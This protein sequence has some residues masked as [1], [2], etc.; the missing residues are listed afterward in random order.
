MNSTSFHSNPVGTHVPD[1]LMTV[2]DVC[3]AVRLARSTIHSKVK[4][5]S[6]PSPIKLS[7]RCVRWRQKAIQQWIEALATSTQ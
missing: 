4:D 6:F 1:G 5:G 7:A 2:K 3:A